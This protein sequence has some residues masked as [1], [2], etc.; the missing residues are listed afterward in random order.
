M[1]STE[2]R[3]KEANV[4]LT[5]AGVRLGGSFLTIKDMSIKPDATLDKKRF[6]GMKRAVGDYDVKGYDI[7]FKT[8]K[9]DHQWKT[10]WRLFELADKNGT[11]PPV[12][13]MA[14]TYSY[15]DGSQLVVTNTLHGDLV[16]VPDDF[17]VPE[18]GYLVDSWKGFA[19]FFT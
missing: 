3:A 7:T 12:V 5:V 6:P 16:L 15:R 4:Q 19:S 1:S 8:E 13:T 14:V 2:I 11:P 18:T 10:L 17:P 9:R